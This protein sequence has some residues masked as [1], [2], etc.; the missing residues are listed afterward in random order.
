MAASADR[1]AYQKC[2]MILQDGTQESGYG[3]CV[4]VLTHT[5][6][7]SSCVRVCV[8]VRVCARVCACVCVGVCA[9]VRVCVLISHIK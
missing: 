3:L 6:G 4:G 9:C 1:N 2:Q 8:C 7:L 5:H